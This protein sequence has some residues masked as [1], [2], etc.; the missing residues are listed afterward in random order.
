MLAVRDLDLRSAAVSFD[1]Y[2]KATAEIIYRLPDHPAV[3]QSFVW[4]HMDVAPDYPVLRRFLDYWEENLDGAIHSVRV[5]RQRL[6][7]PY[8]LRHASHMWRLH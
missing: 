2:C 6:V 3:L 1:R 4:Q 7:S 8:E 5:T